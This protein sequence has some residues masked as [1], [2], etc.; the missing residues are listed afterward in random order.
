MSIMANPPRRNAEE[1]FS[2]LELVVV[3]TI[4]SILAGIGIPI[5]GNIINQ[6]KIDSV[7]ASVN[8]AISDCLQKVRL[9]GDPT[10]ITP[11]NAIISDESIKS[12][13]YKVS[14][15]SCSSFMVSPTDPNDKYLFQLGFKISPT[16]DVVK[17]AVPGADRGSLSS[18]ENWGGVNCGV[19]AEQQS[20]WDALAKIE[21]SKKACNDEFYAWLQKPSSGSY[22][23]WD[24]TSKSCTLLT[25]AFE[26]SIQRDEQAVKDARTAK[27]GALCTAKLKEKELAKYD[28]AFTDPDCGT[29][30]FCSGKDLATDSKTAYDACKEQER[31]TKCTAALGSW[32]TKGVNGQFNESGCTAMWQCNGQILT[33]QA[34]YEA[35]SCGC[36]WVDEQ[37]Q[38]GTE[39]K[40]V[41]TGTSSRQVCATTV[42]GKCTSYRTETTPIYETVQVPIYETRKVC[43]K[44]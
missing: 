22:N 25:W 41:Q 18:C 20:I 15:K 17:I 14:D 2:L 6:S 30:Y 27:L 35:S 40:Q 32:K 29:T 44:L 9:G 42:F 11:S 19:S 33:T 16:G 28:G 8:S 23:R 12:L 37:Y 4:L 1:G 7:K 43:K 24:E 26:G 10:G 31:Q 36:T 39:P 38:T 13:G 21:A 3:V 5:I 34:D